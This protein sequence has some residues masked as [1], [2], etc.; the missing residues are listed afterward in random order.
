MTKSV[1]N[2]DK[3]ICTGCNAC[4]NICPKN[5][6]SMSPDSEGFVYPI[7]NEKQCVQCGLCQK[8]C[9][10][11]NNY[12]N[13]DNFKNP[14]VYAAWS[15]DED[16]RRNSTSGGIFSELAREVLENNGC[17]V[18]ARY[19]ENHMVEHCMINTVEDLEKLR[20]SKYSQ[21]DIG[22][23]YRE[24]RRC[25]IDGKKVLFC[26]TPCHCAGLTSY[27]QRKYDNLIVCDFICRGINS[28]KTY[29]KY[30]E[31]LEKKYKSKI[32]KVIFKNKTYGWNQFATLIKFKNG[33]QYLQD[34]NHDLFMKGYI[35]H[36]FYMRL[37]CHECKFKTMP[38]VSDITLGDFWGIGQTRPHLD[39]DKGTSV[40]FINSTKGRNIFDS[41]K[42]NIFFEQCAFEEAKNGNPYILNPVSKNP[43]RAKFLKD[44][45]RLPF[46]RCIK[47]YGNE[48]IRYKTKILLKKIKKI[49]L[50]LV[51]D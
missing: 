11:L 51:R 47:K 50:N 40:V 5:A 41:I 38:R 9:P 45:D 48:N 43:N 42:K 21:S 1:K 10:P 3:P 36:N 13:E 28:P 44:L 6:I 29:T 14:E 23:V 12:K 32:E 8:T 24:I 19:T 30:L 37:S 46:D 16:I 27:L 31:M 2:I 25:L 4:Y 35:K 34:R 17:V 15:L 22:L 49:I 26:G 7:V 33:E 20:Q 18:G 39:E